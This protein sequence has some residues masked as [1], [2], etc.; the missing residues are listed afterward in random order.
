VG[1]AGGVRLPFLGTLPNHPPLR[2]Y[3]IARNSLVT[4]REYWRDEPGWCLRRLVRLLLGL[5]LMG[6]LER[7]R[8]G[9]MR[10][11]LAGVMDAMGS[12][13]GPYQHEWLTRRK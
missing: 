1:E 8:L 13:T 2:K 5:L 4:I 9:K 7:N 12:R 10:A 11:F 3:Y 6:L